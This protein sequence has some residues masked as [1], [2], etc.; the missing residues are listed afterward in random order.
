[1]VFL[2]LIRLGALTLVTPLQAIVFIWVLIVFLG[3]QRNKL[4]SPNLAPKLNIAAWP[5]LLLNSP[6]SLIFCVTLVSPHTPHQFFSVITLVHFIWL[7]IPC[8]MLVQSTS[9]WT[10]ILFMRTSLLVPLLHD[11]FLLNHRLLISLPRL[12]PRMFFI[13]SIASLVCCLHHPPTCGGLIRKYSRRQK[14]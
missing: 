11:M 12:S 9:S 2:M 1:M 13:A 7:S 8:F 4:R 3:P 14:I 6:G 5:L 10:F